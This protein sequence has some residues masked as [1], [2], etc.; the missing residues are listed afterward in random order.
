ML[1]RINK[2]T[3]LTAMQSVMFRI[4]AVILALLTSAIFIFVLGRNPLDVYTSMLSGAFG[5][6]YKILETLK[7]TVPLVITSL[8]IAVAFRMKFW[9]IGAEG[10]IMM[11]ALF[12]SFFALKFPDMSKPLLLLLMAAA[13]IVGGGLWA[14]VPAFF[15]ANFNTNETLFTLMMNYIALKWITYL[16][17]GPW[18]DPK[19]I[20]FPKIP[21][22][23]D[24]AVLPKIFGLHIGW[25]VAL[26]LIVVMHIFI[27]HTKKGY[28]ISVI[29]ESENTARY[30]GMNVKKII[31]TALF[32]SG[33][34]CGLTGMIQASAVSGT[35]SVEVTGGVGNTAIITSWLSQLSA[36]VILLVSF[37]FAILV[38]GG[39]YIQTAFQIPQ[40]AAQMLQGMIL[41]FVLGSEFFIQYKLIFTKAI[42]S[43]KAE[44]EGA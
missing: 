10:Q 21:N 11:G 22:F 42:Y 26:I 38:Q 32:I 15:K 13:G 19:A 20:G 8:G 18:K 4:I 7:L 3:D 43:Q 6:K 9:N 23:S 25:I 36:P 17:Y 35:L 33:G 29:G 34:L 2:R 5:S 40:S 39:S 37:L 31:I 44:K 41:F 14:A 30:A 28:E 16:Q 12:A 24:N 1:V 27:K